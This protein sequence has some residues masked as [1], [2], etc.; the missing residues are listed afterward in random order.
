[1]IGPEEIELSREL[2]VGWLIKSFWTI[3]II[4]TAG[5]VAIVYV[6]KKI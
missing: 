2:F 3:V 5:F 4:V 1:M 6:N